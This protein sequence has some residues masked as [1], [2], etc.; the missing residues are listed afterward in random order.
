MIDL[1]LANSRVITTVLVVIFAA[2]LAACYWRR[3]AR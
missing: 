3:R 2:S 1:V